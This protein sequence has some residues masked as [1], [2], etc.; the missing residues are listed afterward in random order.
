MIMPIDCEDIR[1]R[2][3]ATREVS[4]GSLLLGNF[5]SH[6]H[7]NHDHDGHDGY[8]RHCSANHPLH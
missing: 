8:R 1:Y 7:S 6:P 2:R 3:V 4:I 5:A